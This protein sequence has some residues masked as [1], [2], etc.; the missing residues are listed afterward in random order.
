MRDIKEEIID[1]FKRREAT[2]EFVTDR[3]ISDEDFNFI[4][5]TGRLSPSSFGWEPWKFLVVQ[6]KDI[7]EKLRAVSW[8][9]QKQLPT[10][11]H[12][13]IILGRK[14]S[15]VIPGAE[16]LHHISHDVNKL[17]EDIEKRKA[18]AFGSFQSNDFDLTNDEKIFDW[19]SKQTYL[20]LANMMSAAAMI[21]IDSCPMEGFN[22]KEVESILEKAKLI[23]LKEFGV[24]VMVA[25][26]YRKD[27]LPYQKTRRAIGEVVQWVK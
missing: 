16:Y 8:G 11:S 20:P 17:P 19:V 3:K 18:D 13:V 6:N 4:L 9:A 5:E 7:R 14:P 1:A 27:N 23:D 15:G 12:F 21:G 10:A 24:V 26:G 22:I 2:K 25:F